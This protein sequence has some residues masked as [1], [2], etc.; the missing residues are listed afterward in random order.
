MHVRSAVPSDA[1][2]IERVARAAWHETYASI[3][4][5]DRIDDIVDAWYDP[6]DLSSRA[7]GGDPFVVAV[8]DETVVGF[9][10]AV[11]ERDG[12][13]AE[14]TRIYVDPD[15]WGTGTGT[16]LLDAVVAPLAES[17]VERLWAIVAA[18]N[19]VGRSF[20]DRRGFEVRDRRETNLSDAAFDVVEV[21]LDL[22]DR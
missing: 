14:L 5:A 6:D 8:D 2:G 18:D 1:E 21:V 7:A 10:Q 15:H 20:Y 19:D 9:A 17:G 4:S 22:R 12:E 3:L 13:E 16:R 11:P